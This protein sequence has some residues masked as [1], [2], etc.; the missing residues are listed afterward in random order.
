MSTPRTDFCQE[1]ASNYLLY[2]QM[3]EPLPSDDDKRWQVVPAEEMR[4]LEVDL[5]EMRHARDLYKIHCEDFRV[6]L[7]AV[8]KSRQEAL[9]ELDTLRADAEKFSKEL[10]KCDDDYRAAVETRDR[11]KRCAEQ[12]AWTGCHRDAVA[13]FDKLSK[14]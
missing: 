2:L 8:K 5:A 4:K 1:H 9:Q 14:Q 7:D 13:T 10:V 6:E 12:L 11:W 3:E